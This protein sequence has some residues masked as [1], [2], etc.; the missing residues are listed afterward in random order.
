[1]MYK[2]WGYKMPYL[3]NYHDLTTAIQVLIEATHCENFDETGRTE[4]DVKTDA[5]FGA[6]H[7]VSFLIKNKFLVDPPFEVIDPRDFYWVE[8]DVIG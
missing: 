8:R 1:M 6:A 2:K 3:L 5:S 7:I 4:T